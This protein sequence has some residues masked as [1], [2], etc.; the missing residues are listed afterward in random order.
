MCVCVVCVFVCV[1]CMCEVCVRVCVCWCVWVVCV[2]QGGLTR[3]FG[4]R[5]VLPSRKPF[6]WKTGHH[7]TPRPQSGQIGSGLA[8]DGQF[9]LKPGGAVGKCSPLTAATRV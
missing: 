3:L 9:R 4:S 5:Y 6:T 2:C 8:K 1:V 7:V